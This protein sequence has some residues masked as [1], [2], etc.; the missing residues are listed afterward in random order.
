MFVSNHISKIVIPTALIAIVAA[1][2]QWLTGEA[3][4]LS[5]RGRREFRD[6]VTSPEKARASTRKTDRSLLHEFAS[7]RDW[8]SA[9]SWAIAGMAEHFYTTTALSRTANS[10]SNSWLNRTNGEISIDLGNWNRWVG[11]G[12]KTKSGQTFSP[13][14]FYPNSNNS[15]SDDGWL[16]LFATPDSAGSVAIGVAE[17]TRTSSGG[18]TQR[19][20]GH[21][22]PGNG[23]LNLGTFSY[24]HGA[25]TPRQADLRQ[26]AR[27]KRQM[28]QVKRQ[29]R[30]RGIDLSIL[31]L[32]VAAD[33]L[34]QSPQAGYHF[35]DN[36]N[37]AREKGLQGLDALLN[38]RMYSYV[39][40][41]TQS[42]EAAGFGNSWA[43]LKRDQKRRLE[44]IQSA[45]REQG[46]L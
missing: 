33:L 37:K 10:P 1:L 2:S 8:E 36:L 46:V 9:S 22:D 3:E 27:L 5:L 41:Q 17:G 7:D 20:A 40:P 23:A 28:T 16:K 12:S 32:V 31:D 44:A 43:K 38:A 39:N 14:L 26:L 42:L 13:T 19:Y 45:L 15:E 35:P 29:A 6:S 21:R 24:Q 4:N 34:N 25:N 11:V 18:T 30:D